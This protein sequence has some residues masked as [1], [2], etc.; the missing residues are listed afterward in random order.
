M[1][2]GWQDMARSDQVA[3]ELRSYLAK[4]DFSHQ[5]RLPPER[6][7][8]ALL[9]VTRNQLRVGLRKLAAEGVIWRHVGRGTYFGQRPVGASQ[10]AVALPDLVAPH[11]VMEARLAFEP[12]LA[13]YAAYRATPK[14]IASIDHCLRQMSRDY[15]HWD[16]EFHLAIAQ[17]SGNGLMKLMFD[18]IHASRGEAIWKK[19]GENTTTPERRA[20]VLAEHA[21]IAE[22]IRHRHPEEAA[23]RM[24][25]HL[26]NTKRATFGDG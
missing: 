9:G 21:A 25:Q 13:K 23:G 14:D 20:Q 7:L 10:P 12:E 3:D 16:R 26:L 15:G 2:R 19:L 5:Q 6:D 22:A 24:R 17:A 18:M 11:N 1:D 8:A 4:Q